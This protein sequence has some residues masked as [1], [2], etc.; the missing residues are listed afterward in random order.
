MQVEPEML[1]AE[2]D[3]RYVNDEL[4]EDVFRFY[5]ESSEWTGPGSHEPEPEA[6]VVREARLLDQRNYESWLD[7]FLPRCVY[8]VPGREVVGDPREEPALHFDD[9]RRLVDRVALIRTGFLH[10]QTPPSVTC[11]MVGSLESGRHAAG[12]C[13]VFSSVLID[14]YRGGGP[15]PVRRPPVPPDR[16]DTRRL[17]DPVPGPAPQ[18][19]R[20]EPGQH[21]LHPLTGDSLDGTRDMLTRK[22]TR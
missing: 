9:H 15:R 5:R 8:W 13:D 7:L 22:R 3:V 12:T 19:P 4:Y 21:H 18:R 17:G 20:R 11:R 2:E 6:V 16:G 10:A 14:A 1:L